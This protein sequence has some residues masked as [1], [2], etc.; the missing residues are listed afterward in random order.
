MDCDIYKQFHPFLSSK[1][2]SLFDV[3]LLRTI[4]NTKR[5]KTEKER[6]R[7]RKKRKKVRFLRSKEKKYWRS[8]G[9]NLSPP[10]LPTLLPIIN[11]WRRY[12]VPLIR[13]FSCFIQKRNRNKD[14]KYVLLE[15][16]AEKYGK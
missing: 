2:F 4:Y 3:S 13:I 10:Y 9:P 14:L 8:L 12:G 7:K 5:R 16:K 6:E 15:S 1:P 11:K